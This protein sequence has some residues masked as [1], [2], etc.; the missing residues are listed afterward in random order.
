MDFSSLVDCLRDERCGLFFLAGIDR[1][2]G[3]ERSHKLTVHTAPG[4]VSA[5]QE[6]HIRSTLLGRYPSLLVE[7]RCHTSQDLYL[8]KCLET[9]SQR[10][11]H[12]VIVADPT[13]AFARGIELVNLATSLRNRLG[14]DLRQFYWV[15]ERSEFHIVTTALNE[16][17][18]LPYTAKQIQDLKTVVQAEIAEMPGDKLRSAIR[19]V[20]I[21]DLLPT[22]KYTPIDMGSVVET[23]TPAEATQVS[24]GSGLARSIK[25]F[26]AALI[27]FGTV[28]TANAALPPAGEGPVL[29]G[30][31]ISALVGLTTLGENSFGVR[32]HY[33]AI[34]GLRLYLGDTGILL[35]STMG[36]AALPLDLPERRN[37]QLRLK[38][39]AKQKTE[40]PIRTANPEEFGSHNGKSG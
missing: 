38:S 25:R 22:A 11:A 39:D 26:L 6:Q 31:G 19:S 18:G 35:A 4:A 9:F 16:N 2:G 34:G 3:P 20:R 7:L 23:A 10:F 30:P 13:G 5:Q 21:A 27:G 17:T 15:P 14:A 33:R 28:T 29:P 12:E 37:E 24:N 40:G 36:S 32:N 8:P 1:V